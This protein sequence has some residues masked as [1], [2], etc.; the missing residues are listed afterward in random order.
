MACS[1]LSSG[2]ARLLGADGKEFQLLVACLASKTSTPIVHCEELT[3]SLPLL[4]PLN[5][6][7][8][9]T[10]LNRKNKVRCSLQVVKGFPSVLNWHRAEFICSMSVNS[11]FWGASSKWETLTATPF[12]ME[13]QRPGQAV[14]TPAAGPGASQCR[15]VSSVAPAL[16]LA[17]SGVGPCASRGTSSPCRALPQPSLMLFENNLLILCWNLRPAYTV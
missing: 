1:L 16:C 9:F 7:S 2:S 13:Q 12:V 3:P 14:P 6:Y 8:I 5:T 11:W 10:L 15:Q 17:P 4:A